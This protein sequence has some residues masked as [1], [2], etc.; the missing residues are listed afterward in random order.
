[1]NEKIA[2]PWKSLLIRVSLRFIVESRMWCR[3]FS[4]FCFR[5]YECA[6]FME[7][8]DERGCGCRA[9]P[10][11]L[12]FSFSFADLNICKTRLKASFLHCL[13]EVFFFS[14]YFRSCYH[15]RELV[16]SPW[17][18]CL[19]KICWGTVSGR[20]CLVI[21]FV[22]ILGQNCVRLYQNSGKD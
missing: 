3:T 16:C 18:P 12:R 13:F 17:V 10:P 14:F 15:S 8:D 6:T 9:L 2:F 20:A 1:M 19:F 21:G 22:M 4:A 7:S 11:T 5:N